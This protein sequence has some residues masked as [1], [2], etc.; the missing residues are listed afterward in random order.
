MQLALDQK[1]QL[2]INLDLPMKNCTAH[3]NSICVLCVT[4]RMTNAVRK[5][6]SATASNKDVAQVSLLGPRKDALL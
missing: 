3:F 1:K 5:Q 2:S 6:K 4:D